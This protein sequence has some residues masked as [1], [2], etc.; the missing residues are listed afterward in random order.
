METPVCPAD[1]HRQPF[2]AEDEPSAIAK[3]ARTGT[4]PHRA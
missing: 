4:L 3:T 2:R 1:R